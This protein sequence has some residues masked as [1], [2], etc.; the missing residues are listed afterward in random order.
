[1]NLKRTKKL[2]TKEIGQGCA[3]YFMDRERRMN[4][5]WALIFAQEFSLKNEV[6]LK[7]VYVL[8]KEFLE[9]NERTYDFMLKGLEEVEEDLRKKNI[10][11]VLLTGAPGKEVVKFCKEVSAGVLVTD[12]SPLRLPRGWRDEIAKKVDCAFYE[13]DSRNIVPVWEASDKKEF[14]AYTIRPKIHKKLPEFLEEFPK[15]KKCK[16]GKL[17]KKADFKA[18]RKFLKL[19]DVPPV[20]WIKPGE[21]AAK[22]MMMKFLTSDL[23][24]YAEKRNDP[25][26]DVLSNLSPYLHFGMVSAQR[27]ALEC[28]PE[29]EVFLEELIMRRELADNF[30]FYEKNYDNPEGF[31]DWAKKTIAEHVHD[32]REYLYNQK[33]FEQAK[34]HDE[35][36]N[37][38]QME[39]LLKGK[40]HGFMRMYWAKKIL[41]WTPSVKVAM[42]I[43][44]YLNDKYE[45]D[46]RDSNGYTGIA[47]SMGGVHDRAWF[48]RPV[49][50]KI[51]YMNFNGCKRKFDVAAYIEKFNSQQ[52]AFKF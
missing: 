13:V 40:M 36:W 27:V 24:E 8:P 39:L 43:A 32:P 1:M 9:A 15:V 20:D 25:N 41:E 23:K 4:D 44:I 12:F 6:P 35:L 50:G 28:N 21:R 7:V 26:E 33:Q 47:W 30:C 29:A 19:D 14:A 31:P 51:R 11:F 2:N 10:D 45:L 18:A 3:V 49:F 34:T 38:A 22:K 5:N 37:A 52:N 17:S 42:E 48:T 16:W 46:G